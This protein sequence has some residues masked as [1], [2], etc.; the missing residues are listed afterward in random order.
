MKL[1]RRTEPRGL[2]PPRNPENIVCLREISAKKKELIF[3]LV[4]C[5]KAPP[6]AGRGLICST[7]SWLYF[8]AVAVL[9]SRSASF[10][11]KKCPFLFRHAEKEWAE[12]AR[13]LYF[14]PGLEDCCWGLAPFV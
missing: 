9:N 12:R 13:L 11:A 10:G 2:A 4:R 7:T 8:S 1:Y 3:R 6:D 14:A 5:S